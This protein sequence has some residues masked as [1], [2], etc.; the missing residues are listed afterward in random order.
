ML[1]DK[2]LEKMREMLSVLGLGETQIDDAERYMQ[3][4]L[5]EGVLFDTLPH[6]DLNT[7][8]YQE[9]YKI[10]ESYKMLKRLH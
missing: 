1:E 4:E 5:E 9:S 3:D 7:L 8:S 6:I 10:D 2:M